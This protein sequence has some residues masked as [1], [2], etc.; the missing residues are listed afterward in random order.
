M[1]MV[2]IE[3]LLFGYRSTRFHKED[4]AAVCTALFAKAIPFSQ[5][6][7]KEIFIEEKHVAEAQRVLNR[8]NIKYEMSLPRG[9]L[10]IA[11]SYKQKGA[12]ITALI[13]SVIL[14]IFLSNKVWDIRVEGNDALSD[15]E[16]V[17]LMSEHGLYRGASWRELDLGSIEACALSDNEEIAWININRRGTVAYVVVKEKIPSDFRA[18][19]DDIIYSSLVAT[20][21][22]IIEEVTVESGTAAVK[23]GDV[24]KRGDVLILGIRAEADGGGF[25]R[26]EGEVLGRVVGSVSLNVGRKKDVLV[27]KS[28]KIGGIN[29]KIFNFPINIFK[30]YRNLG[31]E[32][33]IIEEKSVV[34]FFGL[35]NLPIEITRS[36]IVSYSHTTSELSDTEMVSIATY[37][38]NATLFRMFSDVDLCSMKTYGSFSGEVYTVGCDYVYICSVACD[39]PIYFDEK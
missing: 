39:A 12:F 37:R 2:R 4:L 15:S 16:V 25:C 10:G 27:L 24:V 9:L 17:S 1:A 6:G 32:C 26:A 19:G 7:D 23:A 14:A 3:A 22:C 8:I 18:D 38:L 5:N 36:Y 20:E 34:S 29:V 35:C 13:F 21:D 11:K 31:E 28:R 33:D 30:I